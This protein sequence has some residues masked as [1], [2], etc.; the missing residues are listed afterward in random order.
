[1]AFA[2]STS[3]SESKATASGE[4]ALPSRRDRSSVEKI[5]RYLSAN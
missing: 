4:G 1:M 5:F 2:S 3:S